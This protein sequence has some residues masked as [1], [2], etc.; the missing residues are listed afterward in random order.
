MEISPHYENENPREIPVDDMLGH[1]A[2]LMGELPPHIA[3]LMDESPSSS[4]PPGELPREETETK[5]QID[6]NG[7]NTVVTIMP[8][9]QIIQDRTVILPV[10]HTAAARAVFLT[11]TLDRKGNVVIARMTVNDQGKASR[12]S[13]TLIMGIHT[14]RETLGGIDQGVAVPLGTVREGILTPDDG[15][16]TLARLKFYEHTLRECI[17]EDMSNGKNT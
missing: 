11:R 17:V 1:F 8:K 16:R 5:S 14:W 15:A 4:N 12:P 6:K 9:G 13:Q 2:S 3:S 10:T 7:V